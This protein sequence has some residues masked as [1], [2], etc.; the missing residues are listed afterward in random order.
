MNE[1]ILRKSWEISQRIPRGS[2]EESLREFPE[3]SREEYRVEF[4]RPRGIFSYRILGRHFQMN[5]SGNPKEIELH[6]REES[7]NIFIDKSLQHCSI[8]TTLI[9]H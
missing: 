7:L 6:N 8:N 9:G 2:R 5:P 4:C 1:E 3:E